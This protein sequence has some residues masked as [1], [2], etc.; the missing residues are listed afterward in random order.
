MGQ[1]R[2]SPGYPSPA[3]LG[4]G[5]ISRRP[6]VLCVKMPSGKPEAADVH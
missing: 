2:D 4:V 5:A 6:A 1:A 3:F